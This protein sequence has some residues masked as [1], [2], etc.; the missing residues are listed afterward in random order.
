MLA[1]ESTVLVVVDIQERLLPAMTGK[2]EVLNCI[3]QLVDGFTALSL[4]ILHTEQY[5]KGLGQTVP[6]LAAR[7]ERD[8]IEKTCFGCCGEPTF[9]NELQAL[10][11][12][13]IVLVGIE[14]HVCVAQTALQLL[15]QGYEVHVAADAVASRTPANRDVGLRRMEGA[16][17]EVSSVEMALFELLQEG[18][19]DVFK[20]VVKIIK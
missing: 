1:R 18:S 4:P 8:P 16:G 15:D 11:R 10:D 3:R 20:Q 9:M 6:E 7:L 5:P 17:V 14:T 13:Q 12:R 2:D 19:G